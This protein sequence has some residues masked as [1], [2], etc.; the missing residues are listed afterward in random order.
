MVNTF[1]HK[2]AATAGGLPSSAENFKQEAPQKAGG[3]WARE[4]EEALSATT[5]QSFDKMTRA[6]RRPPRFYL[7]KQR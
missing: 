1:V 7:R 5:L 3:G 6:A 4:G 2:R